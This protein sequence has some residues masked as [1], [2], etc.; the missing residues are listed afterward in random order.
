MSAR[1]ITL[2][3]GEVVAF[4]TEDTLWRRGRLRPLWRIQSEEAMSED[5]TSRPVC[6]GLDVGTVRIG[7]ATHTEGADYAMPHRTV[8]ARP[9]RTACEEIATLIEE[10]GVDTVV[11]GWPLDMDG[12]EGRAVRRVQKFL[13]ALLEETGKRELQVQVIE[14]DERLTTTSAE[15]MLVGADV[16]RGRR[17]KVVDQIAAAQILE[18][19]LK[20]I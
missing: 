3:G 12:S 18:G 5:Q 8:E 4:E 17:K 1:S 19:Y 9:L 20:S 15:A 16:S 6:I 7:V 2:K 10:R 13:D 11:V 14:W